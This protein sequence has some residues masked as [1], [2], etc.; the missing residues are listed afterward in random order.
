MMTHFQETAVLPR[1][2][3]HLSS[4]ISFQVSYACGPAHL[5]DAASL[6]G[7]QLLSGRLGAAI[8]R[9]TQIGRRG[10]ER[11]TRWQWHKR[12]SHVLMNQAPDFLENRPPA[13]TLSGH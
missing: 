4:P 7:F 5:I 2:S 3:R 6:E 1:S 8:P 10:P 12:P 11:F 9:F 13:S